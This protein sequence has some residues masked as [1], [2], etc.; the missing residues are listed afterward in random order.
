MQNIRDFNLRSLNFV[1]Y[2]NTVKGSEKTRL[3]KLYVNVEY[4]LYETRLKVLLDLLC[5]NVRKD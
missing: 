3:N 2:L 1:L 5:T 4:Y